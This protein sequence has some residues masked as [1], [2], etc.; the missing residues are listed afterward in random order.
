[1]AETFKPPAPLPEILA[2]ALGPTTDKRTQI[3]YI[4][5][6]AKPSTTVPVYTQLMREARAL[7]LGL[8]GIMN[9]M[10]RRTAALKVVCNPFRY[11]T[12]DGTDAHY[13]AGDT[14]LTLTASAT[15]HVYLLH[16]TNALTK[17]TSG[18][19]ADQTTFS[20]RAIY[21]CDANDILTSDDDADVRGLQL[22]QTHATSSSPTGTTA[23]GFTIDSDAT[24]AGDR[25]LFL[26]L[27]AAITAALKW[28]DAGGRFDVLADKDLGTLAK[29]NALSL[30]VGGTE[31]VD[32]A[33][34]VDA[35]SL[36]IA[37]TP[38]LSSAG[39]LAAAALDS[40][41]LY[42]V[43]AN[44]GTPAGLLLTPAGF[45]GP[46]TTGT[47]AAG[48]VHKDSNGDV[49]H[50][51][52]VGTPGTWELLGARTGPLVVS[53]ADGGAAHGSPASCTIQIK[54][55]AGNNAAAALV[56]EVYLMDDTD[57]AADAPNTSAINVTT[58]TL[59]RTIV[60]NKTFTVKT[61]SSG[62]AMFDATNSISDQVF[63]L[64]KA[65][66]G[67]AALDCRDRGTLTWS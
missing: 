48:E 46:P 32:S 31:I 24:V 37:G 39:K 64:V 16:A 52:A 65:C 38:I 62:L 56:L 53:I 61:N 42:A 34:N 27:T 54:D 9:G 41:L 8:A 58:G 19:P 21:V 29:L 35:T 26:K 47:H 43:G 5:E 6:D 45:S 50:C 23:S 30:L 67:S 1:M 15:N 18:F 59:V 7:R 10:C 36:K 44:G 33:R 4:V 14:E 20:P 40:T 11:R 25:N 49:Y 17:S 60:A 12:A 57:G 28:V 3:P 51:V 22:Y 66:P 2:A 63:V 13:E 55:G